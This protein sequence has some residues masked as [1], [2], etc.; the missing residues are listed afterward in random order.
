MQK[1]KKFTNPLTDHLAEQLFA[2][3]RKRTICGRRGYTKVP[4][5]V[6]EKPT[7]FPYAAPTLGLGGGELLEAALALSVPV[8]A[9]EDERGR[10]Y[11]AAAAL[12]TPSVGLSRTGR[13][14]L[15]FVRVL[16]T[17]HAR[18]GT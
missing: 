9:P 15:D 16:S 2:S 6:L 4:Q 3:L 18:T 17:Y 14:R 1:L 12:S 13:A 8:S 5:V 10:L 7:H 11:K